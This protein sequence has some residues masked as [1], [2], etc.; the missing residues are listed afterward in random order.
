LTVDPLWKANFRHGPRF[1]REAASGIGGV[2]KIMDSK[3]IFFGG[4]RSKRIE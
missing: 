3:I 1:S 4:M 2:G